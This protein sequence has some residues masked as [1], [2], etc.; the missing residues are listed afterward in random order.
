MEIDIKVTRVTKVNQKT[1]TRVTKITAKYSN[2]F[3]SY[4]C[5]IRTANS[6]NF[7]DRTMF[8]CKVTLRKT[9]SNSFNLYESTFS[10]ISEVFVSI[11]QFLNAQKIL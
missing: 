11:Y 9:L 1:L 5:Y 4:E 3:E 6:S 7:Y 2:F 10:S 8:C